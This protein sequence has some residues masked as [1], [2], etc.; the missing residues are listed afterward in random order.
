MEGA[1]PHELCNCCNCCCFPLREAKEKGDYAEQLRCGYVA[2]TDPVLCTAC[3]SCLE[4]CFFEARQ[5][6]N[7]ALHL[8]DERCFGCG[9]CIPNC[10]T[11]AIRLEFQAGRGLL[12]P[13]VR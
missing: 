11:E 10:P 1:H 5:V 4:N 3:G 2:A 9:R 13:S 12:I 8:I 7:D 6:E